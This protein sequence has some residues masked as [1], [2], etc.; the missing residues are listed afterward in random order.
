MFTAALFTTAKT[1]KKPKCPSAEGWMKKT[2]HLKYNGIW[3]ERQ[4]NTTACETIAVW[5]RELKPGLRDQP[6]R[7]G[8]GGRRVGQDVWIPR[9]DSC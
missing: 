3:R 9:A 4:G 1:W 7:A 2:W 5:L 6:R 8:R